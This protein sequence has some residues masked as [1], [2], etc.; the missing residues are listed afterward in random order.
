MAQAKRVISAACGSDNKV[1]CKHS[2]MS[3]TCIPI[4]PDSSVKCHVLSLVYYTTDFICDLT[5]DHCTGGFKGGLKGHRPTLLLDLCWSCANICT[6]AR[7][8]NAV[9]LSVLYTKNFSG[10]ILIACITRD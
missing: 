10:L 4:T 1:L 9:L 7:S 2:C 6:Y 8:S 5:P 3:H